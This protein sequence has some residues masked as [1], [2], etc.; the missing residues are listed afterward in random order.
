MRMGRTV[1][2]LKSIVIIAAMLMLVS[3]GRVPNS[4]IEPEFDKSLTGGDGMIT[5]NISVGDNDFTS[6]FYENET[7]RAIINS[8]PILVEMS[9]FNSQEKV[10]T[11]SQTPPSSPEKT[12]ETI[13]SGELYVWSGNRLVLFYTTF[14]NTYGGY[15][16]IGYIEDTSNLETALGSGNVVVTFSSP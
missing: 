13:H 12:P 2:M 8:M 4:A 7:S 3:G 14:S 10:A 9:D 5:V 1:E 6:K 16:P 15:I 11:L